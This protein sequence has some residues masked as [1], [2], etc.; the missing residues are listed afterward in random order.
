MID[1]PCYTACEPVHALKIEKVLS[2]SSFYAANYG[3]VQT[4]PHLLGCVSSGDYF[5]IEHGV[6]TILSERQF[7]IMYK[8]QS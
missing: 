1:L 3:V 6:Q 4:Q 7:N 8:E 5:V 2:D